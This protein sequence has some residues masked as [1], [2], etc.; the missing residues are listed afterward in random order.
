MASSQLDFNVFFVFF[1]VWRI[2]LSVF[3]SYES[4]EKIVRQSLRLVQSDFH[5]AVELFSERV[6]IINPENPLKKVDVDRD[7]KILPG[8]MVGELS[9]NFGNFLSLQKDSL[10]D[11]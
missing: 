7:V 9:D 11:A 3:G 1:G 10:R 2:Y 8:V 5:V 6:A 4:F